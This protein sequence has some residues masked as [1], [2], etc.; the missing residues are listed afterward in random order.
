MT[1][2]PLSKNFFQESQN[3]TL[4]SKRY[5]QLGLEIWEF[6]FL[7]EEWRMSETHKHRFRNPWLSKLFPSFL[8]NLSHFGKLLRNHRDPQKG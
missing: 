3:S 4:S 1:Q 8:Q 7:V 6:N 2:G 5:S